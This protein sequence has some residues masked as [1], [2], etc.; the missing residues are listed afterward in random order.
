[1]GHSLRRWVALLLALAPCCFPSRAVDASA[2]RT[3]SARI[4]LQINAADGAPVGYLSA[5]NF[6][7][8]SANRTLSF[9]LA[10]STLRRHNKASLPPTHL[11]VVPGPF[12][13][14]VTRPCEQLA[15]VL[16]A[17]W[18][19]QL[20]DTSNALP[21]EST[22]PRGAIQ[23]VHGS[24]LQALE[25]L[26]RADGRRVLLYV[27]TVNRSLSHALQQRMA[28]AGIMMYDV[29]GREPYFIDIQQHPSASI[30]IEPAQMSAAAVEATRLAPANVM[31]GSIARPEN[32]LN[33]ALS[34][35]IKDAAGAYVLGT[36]LQDAVDTL[37]LKLRHTQ[38]GWTIVGWVAVDHGPAP[39]LEITQ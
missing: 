3:R 22:C 9:T 11:L 10:N 37:S 12:L 29:G 33:A 7:L 20:L 36:R 35:A 6:S 13:Q 30:P 32:S 26:E 18:K 17:R 2:S 27:T 16:R 34:D 19:V 23:V 38:P 21:G 4:Y 25:A 39:R 8:T 15:P 14:G 24:E 5:R 1:M 31:Q 28:H